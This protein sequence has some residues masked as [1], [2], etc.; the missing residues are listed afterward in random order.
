MTGMFICMIG[1]E[2]SWESVESIGLIAMSKNYTVDD[3]SEEEFL[4]LVRLKIRNIQFD[5]VIRRQVRKELIHRLMGHEIQYTDY[6]P[7]GYE[8]SGCSCGKPIHRLDYGG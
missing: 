7:I 3:L 5:W 8:C 6:G 2:A 1:M 4:E